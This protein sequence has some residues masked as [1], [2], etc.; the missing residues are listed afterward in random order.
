VT[1]RPG[2]SFCLFCANLLAT[3]LEHTLQDSSMKKIAKKLILWILKILAKK[4]LKKFRGKVIAVV[5]SIGKTSTKEAIFTVL[6]SQF[7]VRKNKGNMN[8]EFGFLLSILEI[9][10][11]Y[12]SATKWTWYLIKA[13]VHSLMRDHSEILLLELGVD[14]PG[15][16]DFLISILRL[17][18][19]VFTSIAPVHMDE[20][21][22]ESMEAILHEKLKATK[23]LREKGVAIFNVDNNFLQDSYHK[24]DRK[25][26]VSFGLSE[27]ADFWASNIEN[28]IDG[29][30]FILHIGH[31]GSD[32]EKRYEVHA[33][34]IG[35]YQAYVLLPA[36]ACGLKLGM[37][38]EQAILALERYSLPPGRMN[39][40][41]GIGESVI[42][43]SSY[44][45]SPNALKEALKVLNEVSG[46][47]RRI[48]VLGNM[49]EL[50]ERSKEMH[51]MIGKM[52]PEVCDIL[53]TV[54]KEA[55]LIGE[56]AV[57]RGM[58]PNVFFKFKTAQDAADFFKKEVKKGDVILVK[59]SQNRV[60]LEKFV[61]ELMLRPEDAKDLLVRQGREWEA[62]M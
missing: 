28:S 34:V 52:I 59:G 26:R 6:N 62:K 24:F 5:G 33:N 13:F 10:S 29:I 18:M 46:G 2:L 31:S 17:D 23:A 49:N 41:E 53:L 39:K 38:P 51:E 8:N 3:T 55:E 47:H 12:S 19:V 48:A 60:R 50:G 56:K 40:I 43:D 37:E 14:K 54:G 22:F 61:K 11:G 21:Q 57:E 20:G 27:E 25:Q 4:R 36:L 35:Q 30:K 15:D 44:N 1:G 16:M 7:K 45:S 58:D 42:L 9:N 32:H